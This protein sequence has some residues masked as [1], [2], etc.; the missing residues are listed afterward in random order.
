MGSFR[1]VSEGPMTRP[2]A[3][4]VHV[5]GAKNSALK[6]MAA[7]L[8]APGRSVILATNNAVHHL[9]WG[10]QGKALLG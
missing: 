4:M 10:I 9:S 6:L 2:L 1:V 5:G 8:L 3:G 7:S